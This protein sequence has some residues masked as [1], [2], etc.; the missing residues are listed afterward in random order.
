MTKADLIADLSFAGVSGEIAAFHPEGYQD[1]VMAVTLD[2]LG[3]GDLIPGAS[4]TP[5]EGVSI[6][7][8]TLMMVPPGKEKIRS[9]RSHASASDTV[10]LYPR[11]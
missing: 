7:G 8:L 1:A 6:D 10:R 11:S 2:P 3:F 9:R 4:G 5:L